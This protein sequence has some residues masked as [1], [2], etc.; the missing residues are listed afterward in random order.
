MLR[1][2]LE[3][4]RGPAGGELHEAVAEDRLS[5]DRHEGEPLARAVH[6]FEVEGVAHRGLGPLGEDAQLHPV[7]VPRDE[8]GPLGADRVPEAIGRR[9]AQHVVP[10][11]RTGEVQSQ[12]AVGEGRPGPAQ[13]LEVPVAAA[14]ALAPEE[15]PVDLLGLGRAPVGRPRAD[16]GPEGL[17]GEQRPRGQLQLE[18]ERARREQGR[19]A[20]RDSLA[21]ESRAEGQALVLGEVTS[22]DRHRGPTLGV[23]ARDG[24]TTVGQR[25]DQLGVREGRAVVPARGRGRLHLLAAVGHGAID[26][27]GELD[28]GKLVLGHLEGLLEG[29][30]VGRRGAEAPAP[31]GSLLGELEGAAHGPEAGER[32]AEPAQPAARGVEDLDADLLPLLEGVR[33]AAH[34]ARDPPPAHRLAGTVRRA[35]GPDRP[36]S[37][38]PL[39]EPE[40]P[41]GQAVRRYVLRAGREEAHPVGAPE[42]VEREA[43]RPVGARDELPE[44][45][46]ASLALAREGHQGSGASGGRAGA[47]VLGVDEDL[48]ARALE[49]HLEIAAHDERGRPGLAGLDDHGPHARALDRQDHVLAERGEGAVVLERHLE[50]LVRSDEVEVE[51]LDALVGEVLPEV[52]LEIEPVQADPHALV[53]ARVEA[54]DGVLVRAPGLLG[55]DLDAGV[56]HGGSALSG[57]PRPAAEGARAVRLDGALQVVEEG[58]EGRADGVEGAGGLLRARVAARDASPLLDRALAQTAE[59]VLVRGPVLGGDGGLVHPQLREPQLGLPHASVQGPLGQEGAVGLAR[60]REVL[61]LAGALAAREGAVDDPLLGL[62]PARPG[63]VAP[64]VLGVGVPRAVVLV[65]AG[66]HARELEQGLLAQALVLGEHLLAALLREVGR[67]RCIEHGAERGQGRVALAGVPQQSRAREAG[68]LGLLVSGVRLQEALEGRTR[69]ARLVL[70][71]PGLRDAEA[72]RGAPRERGVGLGECGQG[73][74]ELLARG[75]CLA[76]REQ[77]PAEAHARLVGS[78]SVLEGEVGAPVAGRLIG[79]AQANAARGACEEGLLPDLVRRVQLEHAPEQ[80][81][82]PAEVPLPLVR[83]AR[84]R[85][86]GEPA[87]VDQQRLR[88]APLAL[89]RALGSCGRLEDLLRLLEPA[90]APQGLRAPERELLRP[91]ALGARG[92]PG[93]R[94]R[95][96]SLQ[97]EGALRRS[98]VLARGEL[99]VGHDA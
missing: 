30:A 79:L 5:L 44:E 37:L 49:D 87:R 72:G 53:V 97:G 55:G 7:A 78:R 82:R 77:G 27:H 6:Q 95:E 94:G 38:Q 47:H 91:G 64:R 52:G 83:G 62:G 51:V 25:P 89:G 86:L 31:R 75:A 96:R 39:R 34:V 23:G 58:L 81:A 32:S 54:Q 19:G 28:L 42:L 12:V 65:L 17:P 88:E 11:V 84:P 35:V 98:H 33:A 74:L 59:R 36:A 71:A 57:R 22:R 10:A 8:E 63:G 85:L 45:R 66:Q 61:P 15:D 26:L 24:L 76:A 18:A 1:Q 9:R 93:V 43:G 60:C 13:D 99:L 68:C 16:G 14:R 92:Q 41:E 2:G 4:E 3:G 70:G 56:G 20:A 29:E 73:V 69:Q 80:L 90:Q 67:G 40:A 46:A 48:A 21:G 50:L